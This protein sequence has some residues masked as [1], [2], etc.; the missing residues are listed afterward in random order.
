MGRERDRVAFEKGRERLGEQVRVG[1]VG[2]MKPAHLVGS[3]R[4]LSSTLGTLSMTDEASF[5]GQ[6]RGEVGLEKAF[7]RH[8]KLL[9]YGDFVRVS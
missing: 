9:I 8:E 2:L 6:P 1:I 5:T 3:L 4:T 7:E